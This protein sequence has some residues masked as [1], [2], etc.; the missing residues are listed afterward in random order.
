M[1]NGD[2]GLPVALLCASLLGALGCATT[3]HPDAKLKGELEGMYEADQ[4]HR[5]EMEAVG[6]KYGYSSPEI[7]ELWQKQQPI[8]QPNIARLAQIIE[9]HGWPGRSLVGD[10]GAL[11]AFL[12]LQHAGHSYQKKYLPL[13]RAAVLQAK[14]APTILR[15]L[16]IES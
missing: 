14:R 4:S 3:S 6:T 9:E 12:V 2:V 13:V 1:R 10:K 11:A 16:K 5:S 8:D 7:L 15:C